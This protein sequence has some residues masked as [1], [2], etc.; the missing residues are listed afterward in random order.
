MT[1]RVLAAVARGAASTEECHSEGV[2]DDLHGHCLAQETARGSRRATEIGLLEV[3]L[4]VPT[5]WLLPHGT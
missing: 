5:S 4:R 3:F 2:H 1:R